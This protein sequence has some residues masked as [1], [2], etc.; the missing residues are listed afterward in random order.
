MTII[1]DSRIFTLRPDLFLP[2]FDIPYFD[3]S[4]SINMNAEVAMDPMYRSTLV[5]FMVGR[6]QLRDDEPTV[7]Q[8]AGAFLQKFQGQLLGITP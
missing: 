2:V 1:I 4:G 8:R 7:D 3:I 5:Y 6:A